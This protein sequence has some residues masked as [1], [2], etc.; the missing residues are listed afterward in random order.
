MIHGVLHARR[1]ETIHE[2]KRWLD[3]RRYGIELTHNLVNESPVVLEPFD[4]RLAI[5]LPD[6]VTVAGLE[7]NP[8]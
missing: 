8:R 7:K 6:A 1:I 4:K 3:I 2:G 5:Q